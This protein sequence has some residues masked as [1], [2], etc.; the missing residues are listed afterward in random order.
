LIRRGRAGYGRAVRRLGLVVIAL[1]VG[2]FEELPAPPGGTAGSTGGAATGTTGTTAPTSGGTTD[3]DEG[4]AAMTT[5][6][7]PAQGLFAC[8]KEVPCGPWDCSGG[9][10]ALD[11]PAKCVLTALRDRATGPLTVT[12]CDPEC[13]EIRVMPR[14]GGGDEVRIQSRTVAPDPK[15]TEVQR[16]TLKPPEQFTGCLTMYAES[17]ADPST[18][19]EG[20]AADDMPC[21]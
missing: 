2:C 14:G 13:R 5:G 9:C 11:G 10:P 8:E 12:R 17:C 19:M 16:C 7:A 18:W 15:Y 20:C 4:T 1:A 6:G 21:Q 3:A